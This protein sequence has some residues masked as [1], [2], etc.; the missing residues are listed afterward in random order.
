MKTLKFKPRLAT[1]F[2]PHGKWGDIIVCLIPVSWC[3]NII[4][5]SNLILRM[6]E[7]QSESSLFTLRVRGRQWY[8]VYKYDFKTITDV[9]SLPKNV[10]HNRWEIK[11]PNDLHVS[12]DYLEILQ[13]R[14]YNKWVRRYWAEFLDKTLK[15][16]QFNVLAP[17]EAKVIKPSRLTNT[18]TINKSWLMYSNATT[19]G[20]DKQFELNPLVGNFEESNSESTDM[21]ESI[22]VNSLLNITNQKPSYNTY[23]MSA[24]LTASQP[25][26]LEDFVTN[27]PIFENLI[28]DDLFEKNR[29]FETYQNSKFKTHIN[30]LLVANQNSN[31]KFLF[32]HDYYDEV[33]RWTK[34]AQGTVSPCR[35]VKLALLNEQDWNLKKTDL[36]LFKFR[37][38]ENE[39]EL[40]HKPLPQN[41]YLVMKQ[42]RYKP[43]K[44]VLPWVKY[45]R[46][47]KT[48][49]KTS[50]IKSQKSMSL[51]KNQIF[52]EDPEYQTLKYTM[53]KK[54]KIKT[55][56]V[57]VVFWKRLL[58][59]KRTLVL[60]AHVNITVIT[61]SYDII[62]S[63]F[64]PGLGLKMDCIP[65][66]ATH[67]VLH[68]DNVGFYYG[69]CAEICGRYH[70]HMPIRICALPFDHFLLWWHN[71]GL[72]KLMF[73][74]NDRQRNVKTYT[75]RKY[76]W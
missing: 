60:P 55:N 12:D 15:D 35:L 24:L 13:L 7:W 68:I 19:Q 20:I 23:S 34:R 10:G 41:N 57:P 25:K 26:E 9:I 76:I 46:D 39:S 56:D 33:T 61:N 38:N 4:S 58:R 8:W 1:S 44:K 50:V 62:H 49:K 6:I 5:N 30:S 48:G 22:D 70:H 52:V 32:N 40:T 45:V 72:A 3:V 54:N 17:Q 18:N 53:L 59:T 67:H 43:L 75:L 66:R 74:K 16:D 42:K 71:F 37:F 65:G 27:N 31:V 14:S 36:S 11:L 51:F 63:W 28:G 64:I 73:L 47:P 2:R 69:Q 21:I 29:L